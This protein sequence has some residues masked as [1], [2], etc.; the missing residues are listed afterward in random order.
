MP[1]NKNALIRYKTID[2]CLRN[3]YRRWTLQDLV[4]AC[5][6]ALYEMEG[7]TKG[8]SVRTV[9][10]DIQMMRSDKLGYNAPIEVY[11]HK[12]YRYEDPE[13]SITNMPMSQNDYEMMKEAIDMLRQLEDF[14]DF[15]QMSDIMRRLQDNLAISRDSRK[16]IVHF[17][18]MRHLR[19]LNHLTPLY[20]HILHRQTLRIAYQ[21]FTARKPLEFI[22]CP[23]MLKEYRNRWFVFGGRQPDMIIYNLALDRIVSIETIDEPYR[24]NPDFD[25]E[26]FFDDVV[27]VTKKLGSKPRC[28]KFMATA[29]QVKY[30]ETKPLHSSQTFVG[31]NPLDGSCVYEINVVVN[32]ELYS[33]FLSY[34]P[35]LKIISPRDVVAQMRRQTQAAAKLYEDEQKNIT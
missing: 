21:S 1:A 12:Y 32:Y 18:S 19:G 6:D 17:E 26:H 20:N 7:I 29:A 8:V 33:L 3:P 27:G 14:E 13:F 4:E 35:G 22:F 11:D 9:Q 16:P 5:S 34:G 10:A 25:A 15:N 28:I 30:V 24:V 2:N 23:Y 31:R